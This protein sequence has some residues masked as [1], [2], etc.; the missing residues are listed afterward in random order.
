MGSVRV[1]LLHSSNHPKG[2]GKTG[3]VIDVDKSLADLW[4]ESRGAE[5]VGVVPVVPV[6]PIKRSVG[7]KKAKK[8]DGD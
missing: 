8:S 4:I 2:K 6:A 7:R 3:D 1:K 5:L